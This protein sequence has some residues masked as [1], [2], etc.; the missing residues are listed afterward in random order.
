MRIF[1]RDCWHAYISVCAIHVADAISHDVTFIYIPKIK[2]M[3]TILNINQHQ[4]TLRRR[5][6]MKTV[7]LAAVA[8]SFML[9]CGA[10]NGSSWSATWNASV[11]NYN[12]AFAGTTPAPITFQDSTVRQLMYVSGSGD[13]LRIHFSNMLGTAPLTIDG[14]RIAVSSGAAAI[15]VAT[16][17]LVNFG[18]KP[19]VTLAAGT[20]ILSD[21]VELAVTANSPLALSIYVKNATPITTVH[22][23]GR[24][25]NYIAA[26]NM[27]SAA[28][29]PTTQ[30]VQFYAWST[31]IDV[32]RND[33]TKVVV[34]FGDSITDGYASSVDANN[35]YPNY[36]SRRLA[37]DA[38]VG[39]VSVVNAGISGNRWKNDVVGP[40][41]EGRF[42]HDV[43]GVTGITHAVI[44]LGINDIGFSGAFAAGQEVSAAQIT[45]AI[46][47]AVAQA[48]ARNVKVLVGTLTPFKGTI[49]K[50]YYSDAGEA[51]RQAVNS[52]IR[53]NT[54]IDGVID[55]D[56]AV[57]NPADPASMLPSY[58]SGDHLHPNDLGYAAMANAA[59]ISQFQ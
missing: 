13:R 36:L 2:S 43:L 3:E 5:N 49:F 42:A 52:F 39:P 47:V 33:K 34:T 48:K 50:G 16:D 18:G 58:D 9:G 23:L 29:L 41:G 19:S 38:T 44:L 17:T 56:L 30:A 46:G 45:D 54:A 53:S 35:R 10:D 7:M 22:T 24:Q 51:K 25:N 59:A 57:R 31:G 32:Q 12:D 55:F 4:T 37:A 20:E 40:K 27:L 21:V 15:N 11:Q 8:G 28:V 26:G 6:F 14:A 1:T